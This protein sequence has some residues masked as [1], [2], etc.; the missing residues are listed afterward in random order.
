MPV[1]TIDTT[2]SVLGFRQFEP[3]TFQPAASDFPLRWTAA[4]LP[5]GLTIETFPSLAATGVASTDVVTAT[6]N[7]FANGQAVY[8]ESLTGGTG[9]AINTPYFVIE[10]STHEFK[11]ATN[12]GGSAIN[13]TADITAAQIRRVSSGA[14]TGASTAAGI[15]VVSLRAINGDGTSAPQT[16]TFGF[17]A[18]PGSPDDDAL[19]LFW[20]TTSGAV[21]L[22]DPASI[23]RAQPPADIDKQGLFAIKARDKRLFRVHL[24]K[25]GNILDLTLTGLQFTAKEFSDDAARIALATAYE[26]PSGKTFFNM[27]V[28]FADPALIAALSSYTEAFVGSFELEMKRSFTLNAS[29]QTIT[30]T[31]RS[32]PVRVELD[33]D[34]D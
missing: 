22:T 28:D 32:I 27:I 1:P 16:F 7:T 34:A 3:L 20:D 31:S 25:G 21:T 33:L 24:R 23:E 5:P 10:R 15:F 12:A 17:D 19:E 30:T 9:L 14:I 18:S 13:F 4:G 29:A 6:G 11:L 8:F 2:Q 26:K